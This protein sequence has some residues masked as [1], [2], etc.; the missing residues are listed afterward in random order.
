MLDAKKALEEN[1]GDFEAA[2]QWL[3]VQ[4]LAGAAKRGDREAGEGLVA[5]SA[6]RRRGAAIVQIRCETDFVAKSADLVSFADRVVEAVL[7][8]GEEAVAGSQ[9]E[10]D[11][12]KSVLKENL[13]FGRVVRFAAEPGRV[14]GTYLHKQNG[15]GVNAVMVEISDGDDEIAHD[16]A[17]HIAF[18]RPTYVSREEVPSDLVAD[19]REILAEMT[20]REGKP[21]AALQKIVDGRLNGWYQDR[22]L[23]EQRYVRDEKRAITDLLGSASVIRFA[24]VLI[25]P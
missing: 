17:L 5:L 9:A 10:L 6:D 20:R 3:R 13:S 22:C 24:Q 25:G 11:T 18:T 7:A 4:G 1:D 8:D 21:E 2:R 15:R 16:C 23:L 14:I 12:L 19:E